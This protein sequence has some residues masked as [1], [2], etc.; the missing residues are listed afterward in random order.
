MEKL[1]AN[2]LMKFDETNSLVSVHCVGHSLGS[3]VCGLTAKMMK[4]IKTIPAE[5]QIQRITGLDPAQP[6]FENSKI[7]FKLMK[8]DAPF[9]DVIHSNMYIQ[10]NF[11]FGL[12]DPIGFYQYQNFFQ[13]V[14]S[15]KTNFEFC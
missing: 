2:K 1:L 3:H 14:F 5:W 9:V 12:P 7:K 10:N 6:C 4:K 8:D 11:G 15:I 13:P